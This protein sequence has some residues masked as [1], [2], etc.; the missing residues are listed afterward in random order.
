[1]S[2]IK[3]K[4]DFANLC[5]LMKFVREYALKENVNTDI[6]QE[7]ELAVEEIL[8]N[9]IKYAYPPNEKEYIELICDIQNPAKLM[10]QI[11]DTGT[12]FDI[13][14]AEKPNLDAGIVCRRNGGIGIHLAKHFADQLSYKRENGCNITT[15]VKRIKTAC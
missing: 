15:L 4:A 10:I 12:P 8:V 7:L 1:M 13:S 6:C 14:K 11:S 9:I 2:H 5:K 3:L